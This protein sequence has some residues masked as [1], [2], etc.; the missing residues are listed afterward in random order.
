MTQVDD[1]E[2]FLSK[3]YELLNNDSLVVKEIQ[4]EPQQID[5]V[6]AA[7]GEMTVAIE[8]SSFASYT[9]KISWNL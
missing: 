3:F 7:A 5:S 8:V 2:E 1:R 9:R 4:I 6:S